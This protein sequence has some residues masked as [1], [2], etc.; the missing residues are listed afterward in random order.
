MVNSKRRPFRLAACLFMALS[1]AVVGPYVSAAEPR[2]SAV[3]ASPPP[4]DDTVRLVINGRTVDSDVP[5]VIERGRTLVPLRVVS[6]N[7]GARVVWDEQAR[8][9]RVTLGTIEIALMIGQRQAE[10]NGR[11]VVL[12]VPGRIIRGRTL[13]PLRFVG[14]SL[15]ALVGWDPVTR[16]VAVSKVSEL[17]G[18]AFQEANG[19]RHL[20]LEVAGAAGG[21][22]AAPS[23]GEPQAD[24]LVIDLPYT[25]VSEEIPA[26]SIQRGGVR[27][28]RAGTLPGDPPVAR[29]MV[30]VSEPMTW[31]LGAQEG[32]GL[33]I[34]LLPVM[35]GVDYL[36][37]TGLKLGVKGV[38]PLVEQPDPVHLYVYLP[39]ARIAAGSR[40]LGPYPTGVVSNISLEPI[41]SPAAS[42]QASSRLAV[43]LREPVTFRVE[44]VD[45]YPLIRLFRIQ[46]RNQQTKEE[47]RADEALA[48]KVIVLDPGHGGEDPGAI[49]P[50]GSQEKV[51]TLTTA[52]RLRTVLE[53]AGAK[54]LMTREGDVS[55]SLYDRA[56]L[57]NNAGADAF[58]SIHLNAS[59]KPSVQGFEV[60]YHKDSMADFELARD[61]HDAMQ[62]ELDGLGRGMFASDFV[63]LRE[64]A[65]ASVLVEA[66]YISNPEEER[67]AGTESFQTRVARA[68]LRGLANYFQPD[69]A[70]ASR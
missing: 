8:R 45:G 37:E 53:E 11:T 66:A 52:K 3:Y 5:P 69:G 4:A 19:A 60:Y 47:Q 27:L 46:Q 6:E 35:V 28:V 56:G 58:I 18:I 15:G 10:V 12:D 33:R 64:T 41:P 14:E 55:V 22:K 48:G 42:A 1:A 17:K 62:L 9:V 24:R 38:T 57:A 70:L 20:K 29:V 63:V 44:T 54:V 40:G 49:G 34:D 2:A 51:F 65:M 21:T 67:T 30:D 36:P 7:L 39:Q 23:S 26:L 13:V 31:E 68:I 50:G 25:V 59:L 16:T 43:E 32:D 61:V